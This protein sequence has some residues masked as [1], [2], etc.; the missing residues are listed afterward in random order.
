VVRE[1]GVCTIPEDAGP[2]EEKKSKNCDVLRTQ[3]ASLRI[4]VKETVTR[5][6]QGRL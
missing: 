2:C 6:G 4:Y 3:S 1:K 5:I